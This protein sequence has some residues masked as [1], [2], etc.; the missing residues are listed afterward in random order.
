MTCVW[1]A[2]P[3]RPTMHAARIAYAHRLVATVA[4][5][6]QLTA[7]LHT[8]EHNNNNNNNKQIQQQLPVQRIQ[9]APAPVAHGV[10]RLF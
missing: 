9:L 6:Q 10:V 3:S 8:Y 4:H 5:T 1:Q 2:A 7:H